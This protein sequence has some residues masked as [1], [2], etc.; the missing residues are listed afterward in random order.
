DKSRKRIA[1]LIY[2][3]AFVPEDGKS[4]S[5]YLDQSSRD[6]RQTGG[7]GWRIPP[8]Q[9][10]P[11]TPDRD[12]EWAAPRRVPQPAKCFSTPIQLSGG[13][14]PPRSYIYCRRTTPD[15]R[16]GQFA[17]RARKE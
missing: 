16:F 9:M 3:D 11:D 2:L 6:A 1:Q 17:R 4:L 12:R 8:M 13:E 15:D 10:P 5:D 7:D 14:L